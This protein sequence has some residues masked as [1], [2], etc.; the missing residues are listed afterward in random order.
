MIIQWE[1]ACQACSR[2]GHDSINCSWVYT[3]CRKP[4][5]NGIRKLLRSSQ[6]TS[7]G[8]KCFTC[9]HPTCNGFQ[10]FEEQLIEWVLHQLNILMEMVVLG[11]G[12]PIT[13]S[14]HSHGEIPHVRS[15]TVKGR[16][17]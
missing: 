5:Y 6:P 7:L 10:W 11:V 2:E 3:R 15:Q 17:S 1:V 4:S 9:Q 14:K 12:Q 8:K 16:E 13:G